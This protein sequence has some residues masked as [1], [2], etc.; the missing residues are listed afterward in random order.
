[1]RP[2]YS[3]SMPRCKRRSARTI[4]GGRLQ[5]V[6]SR[7]SQ[8]LIFGGFLWLLVFY[9]VRVAAGEHS[10]DG[11]GIYYNVSEDLDDTHGEYLRV[12]FDASTSDA[13]TFDITRLD[14]FDDEGTQFTVGNIHQF[15][16]RWFT[17]LSVAGSAGGFF[18]PDVRVD[19]S[20]SR[21]WFNDKRLVTTLGGGYFDAKDVHE[22]LRA[23]V[24]AAYYF[25]RP[26]VLQGGFQINISDPGSVDSTSGYVAAS[27]VRK[28]SRIVSIRGGIG[29][30]AYQAITAT[31][32]VVDF[33]YHSV[34][35]TWREWVG[36]TWGINIAAEHYSS[37]VYDQNG[38][39]LGFFKEF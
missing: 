39:E 2:S 35:A 37:E 22:D 18:W 34:R 8:A 21:R 23:Y 28:K 31:N 29:D 16:E 10:I 26:F 9:C 17:Q 12:Y 33:P 30:Q 14:R 7:M 3:K 4:A 27:Y 25:E 19:G 38:F 6:F 13:F 15:S 20:V 36:K 5:G 11:G 1:M 32:F 24:D